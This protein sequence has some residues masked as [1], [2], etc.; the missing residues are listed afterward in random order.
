MLLNQ[1]LPPLLKPLLL[2]DKLL[3]LPKKLHQLKN[4]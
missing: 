3:L 1:P 2:E 4:H